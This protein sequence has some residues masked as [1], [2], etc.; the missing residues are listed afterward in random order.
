MLCLEYV[1]NSQRLLGSPLCFG[2]HFQMLLLLF[3]N[4]CY[5]VGGILLALFTLG[6]DSTPK[7]LTIV[8]MVKL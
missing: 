5:Y 7:L 2:V 8:T 1:N 3:C 6:A 4:L